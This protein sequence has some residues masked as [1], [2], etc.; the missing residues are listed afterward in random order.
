MFLNSSSAQQLTKAERQLCKLYK[1]L[2]ENKRKTLL[3]FA[4]FLSSKQSTSDHTNDVEI[5][6]QKPV[7]IEAEKNETV[8]KSIKRLKSSYF[9]IDDDNLLHE[10]SA[11]MSEHIMK[12]VPAKEII[13]KI[14]TVFEKFYKEYQT[15]FVK[16]NS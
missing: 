12:G 2:G 8:I 7:L 16:N 6:L 14:E 3:L 9:M 10:I 4:E 1:S 11:L 15:N 13:P 5:V